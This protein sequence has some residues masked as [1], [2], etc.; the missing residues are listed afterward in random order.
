VR[1]SQLHRSLTFRLALLY[2]LVLSA[3]VGLLLALV[4][5]GGV[6]HPIDQM[7]RQLARET[8]TAEAAYR[9]GGVRALEA[10]MRR[11]PLL[12]ARPYYALVDSTGK[13]IA[14]YAVEDITPYREGWA[15]LEFAEIGSPRD[16]DAIARVI[17]VE[18]GVTLFV[19]RETEP[20]YDRQDLILEALGWSALI[21]PTLGLLV[22]LLTS[23]AVSRRI[24][25][26][27]RTARRVM[28]GDLSER[29]EVRGTGDDFDHLAE[30]LNLMLARIED[31]VQSVS[32]VSDHVAHEL[33]TPL[34]RLRAELEV[35]ARDG[36]AGRVSP[37]RVEQAL[38]EANRLQS[39]FDALL[40]IARIESGQIDASPRPLDL[41]RVLQDAVEL[42]Q[43]E[44]D[45]KGVRLMVDVPDGLEARG[46]ANLL[47]QAVCN[48]LDNAVK[49]TPTGGVVTVRALGAD[50]A[51]H[52]SVKDNGPG[53]P[54]EHRS[55]VV[56]RFYRAP[57]TAPTPGLGLGLPLVAAVCV[58]H[59]SELTLEDARPGL[60][61]SISLR[62][63]GERPR[64][65]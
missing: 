26:V 35:L 49:F 46:D 37:E 47:F 14:G 50:N 1:L 63:G 64:A 12:P 10:A 39:T 40:R 43:P 9:S 44:A 61:A 19:G 16:D 57:G 33:R 62:K 3:S 60:L 24:E 8:A 7:E 53:I 41:T 5:W 6:R 65:A 48:L 22:G 52:V 11:L 59:G 30:T 18:P 36:E 29:V 15:A 31:L 2:L 56:E 58:L 45:A 4:W 13:S 51:V 17:Q 32:R 34:T 42:Y 23:L 27:A 25:S 55:R 28:R 20:F 38:A 21:A 54:V